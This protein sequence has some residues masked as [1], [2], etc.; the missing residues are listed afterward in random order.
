VVGLS[1][2]HP[3]TSSDTCKMLNG[4]MPFTR[5]KESYSICETKES[6][7]HTCH[8][9]VSA[10]LYTKAQEIC[11]VAVGNIMHNSCSPYT[12]IIGTESIT[13]DL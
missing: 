12:C 6:D 10:Q 8:V 13:L 7:G 11:S 1:P 5:T 4:N 3:F 2:C 9:N